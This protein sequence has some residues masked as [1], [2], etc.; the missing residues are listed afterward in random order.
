MKEFILVKQRVVFGGNEAITTE[1]R[2]KKITIKCDSFTENRDKIIL[3]EKNIDTA[4]EFFNP[5]YQIGNIHYSPL[6]SVSFIK[7]G[8]EKENHSVLADPYY[9]LYEIV[10]GK[11]ILIKKHK[12]GG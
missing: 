10:D 8:I 5:N 9:K 6:K 7:D 3:T 12:C 1:N 4:R 2:V 11:E